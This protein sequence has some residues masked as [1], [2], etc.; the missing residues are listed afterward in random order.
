MAL[1]TDKINNIFEQI[2][3]DLETAKDM[4]ADERFLRA[5]NQCHFVIKT[6]LKALVFY[7][8]D[9]IPSE[10]RFIDQLAKLAGI[11]DDLTKE[12]LDFIDFLDPLNII[13]RYS[14]SEFKGTVYEL[15]NEQKCN[16]IY[17]KTK[18]FIPWIRSK[19]HR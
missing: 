4:I 15:L 6:A 8:T 17:L 10:I 12:Q 5:G 16:D 7:K 13:T 19:F 14:K 2:N 9:K 1:Y 11:F 18:E 3:N